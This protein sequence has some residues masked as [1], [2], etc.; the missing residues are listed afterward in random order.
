MSVLG[1]KT[2]QAAL[3]KLDQTI[4]NKIARKA[5]TEA[6]KPFVAAARSLANRETGLLAQAQQT[7]V[8]SYRKGGNTVSLTGAQTGWS[9]KGKAR[10]RNRLG[11][12]ADT[13]GRNPSKYSHLVDR[14][15]QLVVGRG[16]N[17][18]VIGTV[19]GSHYLERAFDAAKAQAQAILARRIAEELKKL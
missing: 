7:K 16:K 8:K 11:K 3:A 9:G 6:S 5:I 12:K 19:Q 14:G 1:L 10:K 13:T 17:R 18:R 4:R 2:A 15:H